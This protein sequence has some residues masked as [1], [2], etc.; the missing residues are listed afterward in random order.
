MTDQI[1]CPVCLGNEPK[2]FHR[3]V[4]DYSFLSCRKCYFQFVH[5]FIED[6]K[7]FDDYS[8]TKEYTE[9][10][11]L[12]V[13]PAIFSLTKKIEVVEKIAA[14]NIRFFLDVG[15]GNGLYLHAANVL[16]I[17]NLGTD[18]DRINVE[19]AKGKGLNALAASLENLS[20]D[21]RFDFIHLKAVLHLVKDPS[22]LLLK[23]K[24]F[25]A[26]GGVVYFDVPNQ[27]SLFSRLRMLRDRASYGQLQL[28]LRRG[29]YNY[30]CIKYLCDRVGLRIAK[31]V[32]IY[33]GN[34][35]YYPIL[36]MKRLYL[37]VFRLFAIFR[38]SS[39]IGFYLMDNKD[40]QDGR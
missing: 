3:K 39:F 19:F 7:A 11:D 20:L 8:W 35:V 16:G 38:I 9:K 12:Y 5:P 15:C 10:F 14:R 29:A 17:K 34:K 40:P 24:S 30:R 27:G 23:A 26:P 28:P 1:V 2:N 31:R 32:F 6:E 33:P 37:A 22:G 25:L 36:G 13:G 21:D 4:G 18:I